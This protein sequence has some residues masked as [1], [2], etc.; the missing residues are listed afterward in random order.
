MY[1]WVN[2]CMICNEM[3]MNYLGT[4]ERSKKTIVNRTCILKTLKKKLVKKEDM[5]M[6][7]VLELSWERNILAKSEKIKIVL[8]ASKKKSEIQHQIV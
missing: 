5:N 3:T 2:V 4:S 8:L 1:K 7:N 6:Y